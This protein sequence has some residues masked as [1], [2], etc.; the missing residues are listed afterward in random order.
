MVGKAMYARLAAVAGVSNLVGTRI[1]ALRLPQNVTYPAIRYQQISAVRESAMGA[2]TGD[3]TARMQVDSFAATYAGAQALAKQV[4]L[5]L[6]RWGGTAGGIVVEHVFIANELDR[7]EPEVLEDG[8]SGVPR[9]L[10]D[11]V[12]HFEDEA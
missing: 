6:A 2:D 10:Q 9:V 1:Y 12:V 4:R 11:Y 7:F 5:A 3:V 8:T